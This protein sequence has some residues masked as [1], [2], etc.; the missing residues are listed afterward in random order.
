[1]QKGKI[2]EAKKYFRN[3]LKINNSYPNTHYALGLIAEMEKDLNSAFNSALKAIKLNSK[4]DVLLKNSI[5]L[6]F[7]VSKKLI[8]SEEGSKIYEQYIQKLETEGNFK[9]EVIE[10]NELPTKAKIEFAENH[11]RENHIIKYKSNHPGIEHLIMHELVHLDLVIQAR[12]E[13]MNQLFVMTDAHRNNF[14]EK[15]RTIHQKIKK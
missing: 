4:Q 3:A 11:N 1:M 2:D 6:I 13:Q 14:R 8:K 5:N 10:D 9:I 15:S 7:E 12:K